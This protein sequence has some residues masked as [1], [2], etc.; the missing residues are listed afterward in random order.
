MVSLCVELIITGTT[1]ED[2]SISLDALPQELNAFYDQAW[3]KAIGG[4]DSMQAQHARL[5]LTWA[6][7]AKQSLT[8][9]VLVEALSAPCHDKDETSWS[10]ERIVSSCAGLVS[11]GLRPSAVLSE[12]CEDVVESEEVSQVGGE[13][14]PMTELA[15]VAKFETVITTA[16]STVQRYL[17]RKQETDS[18]CAADV[19]VAACLSFS[20]PSEG[21]YAPQGYAYTI[22]EYRSLEKQ[23]RC[24]KLA[25]CML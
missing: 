23:S 16:N 6:T 4:K 22:F 21:A 25:N 14:S 20:S 7:H 24:V 11:I 3:H 9:N 18:P 1:A 17:K 10:E 2:I 13:D 5:I 15:E 12:Q 19:I 8:I